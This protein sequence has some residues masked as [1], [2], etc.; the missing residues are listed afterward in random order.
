MSTL[1]LPPPPLNVMISRRGNYLNAIELAC[2]ARS[3][4]KEITTPEYYAL[5]MRWS[6][7]GTRRQPRSGDGAERGAPSGR[8]SRYFERER[9]GRPVPAHR[10][11]RR[12]IRARLQEA[13]NFF[14]TG[15][16]PPFC[17]C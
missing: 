1:N 10:L 15:A 5:L 4:E 8:A 3:I 11:A 6:T 9:P 13:F 2:L 7:R 16:R 17:A 14:S 12:K